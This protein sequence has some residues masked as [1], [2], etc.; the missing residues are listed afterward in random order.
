MPDTPSR[1]PAP[2]GP[3]A[4]P[5]RLSL[6]GPRGLWWLVGALAVVLPFGL[7]VGGKPDAQHTAME[8]LRFQVRLRNVMWR[9]TRVGEDAI[10]AGAANRATA[11]GGKSDKSGKRSTG[12]TGP[13][14]ARPPA[15]SAAASPSAGGAATVTDDRPAADAAAPG[16]DARRPALRNAP[17]DA[18]L[19]R[20]RESKQAMRDA[21]REL[22][23]AHPALPA[24]RE[25][26]VAHAV[27]TDELALAAELALELKSPSDDVRATL[28]ATAPSRGEP[29]ASGLAMGVTAASAHASRGDFGAGWGPF[30]RERVRSRV[31]A[32]AGDRHRARKANDALAWS[33]ETLLPLLYALLQALMMAGVFGGG[34]WLLA[35]LRT[36]S[37][38]EK[39]LPRL[40]WLTKRH[41]GLGDERAYGDDPLI[42]LLGFGA[43]LMVYLV[44]GVLIRSLPGQRDAVGL[45]VLFQSLTGAVFAA[46]V[47][48]SFSRT[49]LPLDAARLRPAASETSPL[50]AS[51]AALWSYCFALPPLL[52]VTLVNVLL[53]EI[54][55]FGDAA[56]HPVVGML[57]EDG[58][59][60][61]VAALGLAVVVGAPLGEELIFRGFLYRTFRLRGGVL[62]SALASGAIFA[63]LH[64]SPA[65]FLPYMG[66][67]VAFAL[68]FE[69][70]GSLWA[71]II[72]HGLW[73]AVVFGCMAVVTLS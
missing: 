49:P 64:M 37:A 33:D 43:W 12:D 14:R 62:V 20:L 17:E 47:V 68:V 39:G 66:L 24:G 15:G 69:W 19:V 31:H 27:A 35:V 36:V 46:W 16:E 30:T 10:A 55:G 61:Q 32:L 71:S 5:K 6:P 40:E 73:N 8:A 56:P 29:S 67:G 3:P 60:M 51:T 4:P 7:M 50:R 54:I 45:A 25:M 2:P 58:D 13:A 59:P 18:T 26:L 72:L 52:V 38:R 53:A 70:T 42:P 23:A 41:Q 48:G 28:A 63:L 57:L 21:M 11:S 34:A 1:A 65:A 9:M 22:F 44:A